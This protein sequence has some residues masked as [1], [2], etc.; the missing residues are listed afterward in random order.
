[1]LNS[2]FKPASWYGTTNTDG[3]VIGVSLELPGEGI[4]RYALDVDSARALAETIAN[5]LGIRTNSHSEMSSGIPKRE[6][7]PT[8]GQNV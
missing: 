5:Y 2:D 7:S 6:V 3:K 4:V 1:M 8:E